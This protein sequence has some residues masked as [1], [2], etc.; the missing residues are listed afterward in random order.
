MEEINKPSHYL[1]YGFECIDLIKLLFNNEFMQGIYAFNF[2]KY[3]MRYEFKNKT[4]DLL[5]AKY[6]LNALNENLKT[7]HFKTSYEKA[8]FLIKTQNFKIL[9]SFKK[10]D[11]VRIYVDKIEIKNAYLAR[12][13]A[14]FIE[15][16]FNSVKDRENIKSLDD[17]TQKF[18]N[19][20]KI[21]SQR[22]EN[23]NK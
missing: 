2:L 22:I 12:I 21:E 9:E 3:I 7:I 6:Y 16:F 11:E 10:L 15:L 17:F 1:A 13:V 5:K 20:I 18:D 14:E 23:E 4:N 8:S 19:F